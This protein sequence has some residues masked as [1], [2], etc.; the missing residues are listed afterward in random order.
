MHSVRRPDEQLAWDS[1]VKGFV[2]SPL[3]EPLFDTSVTD[4]DIRSTQA[5]ELLVGDSI[6]VPGLGAEPWE[7]QE[8]PSGATATLLAGLALSELGHVNNDETTTLDDSHRLLPDLGRIQWVVE[9]VT[10]VQRKH[11]PVRER[12]IETVRD[13]GTERLRVRLRD[14]QRVLLGEQASSLAYT[15]APAQDL[16]TDQ[17]EDLSAAG[18]EYKVLIGS[19]FA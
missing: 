6:S 9:K 15:F 16:G 5:G 7:V 10:A 14:N 13:G 3:P 8:H 4:T 11:L 18:Y 1:S 12:W 17:L 2:L 19:G